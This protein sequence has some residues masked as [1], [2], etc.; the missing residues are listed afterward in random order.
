MKHISSEESDK[1]S[2]K[3]T[4]IVVL[5]SIWFESGVRQRKK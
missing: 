4:E 1:S 5:G 2:F 3:L